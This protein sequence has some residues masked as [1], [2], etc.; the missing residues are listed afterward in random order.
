MRETILKSLIKEQTE[1]IP[2]LRERVVGY[3]V[4]YYYP[5]M[6]AYYTWVHTVKRFLWE[7]FTGDESAEE[8]CKLSKESIS[9]EQQEELLAIL[10][11]IAALPTIIKKDIQMKNE[12]ETNIVVNVS[13]NNTQT[14]N[15]CNEQ[16]SVIPV[17]DNE[18][19]KPSS[20]ILTKL[21]AGCFAVATGLIVDVLSDFNFWQWLHSQLELIIGCIS[22]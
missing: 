6:I 19:P 22:L 9:L 17:S 4:N 15:Q 3:R 14:Q 16:K 20:G 11:A 12:K 21:K 8:F 7:Y 5:D 2:T 1:R 13:N 18:S 10:N